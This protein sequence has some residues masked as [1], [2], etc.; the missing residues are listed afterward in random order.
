MGTDFFFLFLFCRLC[1]MGVRCSH[2]GGGGAFLLGGRWW[3]GLP[4]SHA[5][6]LDTTGLLRL[7][8]LQHTTICPRGRFRLHACPLSLPI[9]RD[10]S[11]P[12]A[13]QR[14]WG[15]R[16]R[17]EEVV[18]CR[19][20]HSHGVVVCRVPDDP[21]LLP[22]R[23]DHRHQRWKRG[24][25]RRRRRRRR[26]GRGSGGGGAGVGKSGCR[27][28]RSRRST[29]ERRRSDRRQHTQRISFARSVVVVVL[30]FF[31]FPLFVFVF[32]FF[33]FF[34]HPTKGSEHP[35]PT[36]PSSFT[37]HHFHLLPI[38]HTIMR[39]L[40]QTQEMRRA[41]HQHQPC[42]PRRVARQ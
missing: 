37:H 33:F 14:R 12:T 24:G 22:A 3:G 35:S 23:S 8:F 4:S 29:R 32:V 13:M 2:D 27:R 28:V 10:V 1:G 39:Y 41:G 34:D 19:L 18:T 16:A 17:G 9:L 26:G 7:L 40:P 31:P 20:C 21:R 15:R 42:R 5:I 11:P 36:L 30:F 6:P 38:L 25:G